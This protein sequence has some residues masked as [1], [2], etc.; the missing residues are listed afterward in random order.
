MQPEFATCANG[1]RQSPIDIRGGIRVDLEP[2]AFDY[3][4]SS[5][6]VID[7]GHTVQVNLPPGQSIEVES[8]QQRYERLLVEIL[9]C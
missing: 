2:V 7:N 9:E 8:I 4:A 5:F 1:Q 6:A 3:R